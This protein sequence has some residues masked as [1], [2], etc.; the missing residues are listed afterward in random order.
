VN[1]CS[2]ARCANQAA[3]AIDWRNPKIHSGEKFK[4]W[5]A[6]D[7]HLDYLRGYLDDRGFL[8]EVR[9]A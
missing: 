7:E 9:A 4:T 5:A 2:R 3:H 1:K 6:C 8:L